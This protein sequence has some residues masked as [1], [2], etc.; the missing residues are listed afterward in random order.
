MTEKRELS[1]AKTLRLD[2][3]KDLYDGYDL[4]SYDGAGAARI[5]TAYQEG[6]RAIDA[7][8]SVADV[9]TET[10]TAR[11]ALAQAAQKL[12]SDSGALIGPSALSNLDAD[13][14]SAQ[15]EST[16]EASLST[17]SFFLLLFLICGITALC[18]MYAN[19]RD[20][21]RVRRR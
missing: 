13:S 11:L 14:A 21:A 10:E 8:V 20:K 1:A 9:E 5:T 12:S 18:V 2:T 4:S 17:S 16:G 7:A 15:D 19:V 6:V 3:L